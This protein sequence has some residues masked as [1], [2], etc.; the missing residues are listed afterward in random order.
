[1]NAPDAGALRNLQR[2]LMN[3]DTQ[4]QAAGVEEWV[5]CASLHY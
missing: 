1:M 3:K 5:L 2:L 4:H